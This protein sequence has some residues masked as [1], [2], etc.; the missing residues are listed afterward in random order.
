MAEFVAAYAFSSETPSWVDNPYNLI[1]FF[2]MY[3]AG[4]L[5]I[6]E[7]TI[8]W[9]KGIAS[10]I[11]LGAAFALVEEGLIVK[12][13]FNPSLSKVGIE[14]FGYWMGFNWHAAVDLIVYHVVYS[15][16]IPILLV[17]MIFP[18]S[19]RESWIGNI[20]LCACLI[21]LV[22]LV[23]LAYVINP[24]APSIWQYILAGLLIISFVFLARIIPSGFGGN[25]SARGNVVISFMFGFMWNLIFY[26]I[27]ILAPI[28]Y[29][30]IIVISSMLLWILVMVVFL[31]HYDWNSSRHR[32]ALIIGLIFAL[33]AFRVGVGTLLA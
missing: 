14:G 30:P 11:L 2:I 32:L 23:I 20:G 4:S 9:E 24:Y 18:R 15:I 31:S 7:L 26:S 13:L 27:Y 1:I 5:L 28:T 12:W 21:A 25:G 29:S 6:R 8:R 3:P 17:E 19:K 16:T 33:M 22:G 10:L